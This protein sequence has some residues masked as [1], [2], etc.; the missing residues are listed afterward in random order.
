[1]KLRLIALLGMAIL[2][3]SGCRKTEVKEPGALVQEIE[4]D[5]DAVKADEVKVKKTS[6]LKGLIR[7]QTFDVTLDGWGDVT[8]ASFLPTESEKGN[9]DVKFKL[10]KKGQPFYD[11]PVWECTQDGREFQNVAAVA[12]RDYNDDGRED[13]IVL[14]EYLETSGEKYYEV[15]VYIQNEGR[16]DFVIDEH[17][18]RYLMERQCN[19][20]IA[21]VMAAK[22][23]Y[24]T[25]LK[26]I[27]KSASEEQLDCMTESSEIWKPFSETMEN[28]GYLAV[29]D[30]DGN[31]RLELILSCIEGSGAY[32]TSSF[33]EVNEERDELILCETDFREG[34]SQPD[35]IV[36]KVTACQQEDGT[37]YYVF[38]DYLKAGAWKFYDMVYAL[39]LKDG[40]ISRQL[41]A[42]Q[43]EDYQSEEKL[44]YRD[45]E[46]GRITEEEFVRAAEYR[47][48]GCRTREITL[49]WQALEG[50]AEM[51]T[52]EIRQIL[53]KSWEGFERR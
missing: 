1:M 24:L 22:A 8:F 44:V 40:S 26:G 41:L 7:D 51:D 17:L 32:T 30:L 47:F 37:L 43:E 38:H 18:S 36:D 14:C 3:V 52:E 4:A 2:A 27:E 6:A 20:S 39:C 5:A 29:T 50:I 19:E 46:G 33:Y 28:G 11:F 13:V 23:D 21:A 12:F 9:F 15:K 48:E 10:L 31:G 16:R 42:V 25:S 34:D 49:E 53:E 45:A 35:I